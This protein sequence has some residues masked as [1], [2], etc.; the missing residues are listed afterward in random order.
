MTRGET[1]RRLD[2]ALAPFRRPAT[3]VV[4][5]REFLA[6]SSVILAVE[7]AAGLPGDPAHHQRIRDLGGIPRRLLP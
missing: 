4:R 5:V 1:L 6:A 2:E 3:G 7:A